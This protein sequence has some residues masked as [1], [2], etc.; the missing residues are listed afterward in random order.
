M[1]GKRK[2]ASSVTSEFDDME[3]MLFLR[4]RPLQPP[5]SCTFALI[6]TVDCQAL[7]NTGNERARPPVWPRFPT[8]RCRAGKE[9]LH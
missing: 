9:R 7:V 6:K 5:A 3:D 1:Q 8:H 4:T 2:L